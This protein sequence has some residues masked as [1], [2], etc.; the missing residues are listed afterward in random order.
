MMNREDLTS[1]EMERGR[2]ASNRKVGSANLHG[3]ASSWSI[4]GQIGNDDGF[5]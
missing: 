1:E 2:R 3:L 4:S 5:Q